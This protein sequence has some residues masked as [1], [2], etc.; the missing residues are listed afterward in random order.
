[1]GDHNAPAS[2]TI[3]SSEHQHSP[4]VQPIERWGSLLVIV[5]IAIFSGIVRLNDLSSAPGGLS[6][7]EAAH[8]ILARQSLEHGLGWLV[9]GAGNLSSVLAAIIAGIGTN[10]G[11]DA[12]TPRIAAAL[13]GA[14]SVLFTG[15]WIRRELGGVW[16]IAGAAILAGSFWH[17]LF[18]RLGLGQITGT[19]ALAAALWI[20]AEARHRPLRAAMPWYGGLGVLVGIAFQSTPALRLLPL[21][22]VGITLMAIYRIRTKPDTYVA[23]WIIAVLTAFLTA[24]PW[25]IFQPNGVSALTPWTT[26][27]GL[28][29]NDWTNP[30]TLIGALITT[31]TAV[32]FPANIETNLNLPPSGFL[33]IVIL[34]W[35]AFGLITLFRASDNPSHRDRFI[36]GGMGLLL[37]LIGVS[38]VDAGHPGQLTVISPLLAGLTAYGMRG[39]IGWAR[40]R[41]VRFG[42]IFLS[43]SAIIGDAAW[44]IER[45]DIWVNEPMT[46]LVF[47]PGVIHALENA[48]TFRDDGPVLIYADT[49][50]EI[51][52]YLV[53]TARR[54]LLSS[55]NEL[56]IPTREPAYLLIPGETPRN[57][58]IDEF[59]DESAMTTIPRE[60]ARYVAYRLDD[61]ARSYLPLAIPTISY[62]G[63][64]QFQGHSLRTTAENEAIITIAWRIPVDS[65]P[66]TVDLRLHPVDGTPSTTAGVELPANPLNSPVYHI[67]VVEL[68][69]PAH[70]VDTDLELRVRDTDGQIVPTSGVAEDGYLLLNRYRF[71]DQ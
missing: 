49:P 36:A 58:G 16:G 9:E 8:G 53:S 28:P 20:L 40:V 34:P 22:L 59:L 7:A 66:I 48:D 25:L 60:G 30:F 46:E 41:T 4:L 31:I 2:A 10:T 39:V 15:L 50:E 13:A 56:I 55:E 70:N 12:T 5:V 43:I 35:A 11:F 44:S 64:R 6:A 65:D 61:R 33:S 26:T 71:S 14:G 1:M 23:P 29:G 57:A 21:A 19:L 51:E 17:L 38:A 27:P 63:Q 52:R 42:L 18:S 68:E 37:I 32:A 3:Q 62:P 47:Y 67:Y 45:Y 69:I 24:L 54:H